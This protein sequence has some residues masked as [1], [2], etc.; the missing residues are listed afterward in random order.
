MEGVMT[1]PASSPKT[2]TGIW[3]SLFS[4][5][6]HFWKKSEAKAKEGRKWKMWRL[7]GAEP[8]PSVAVIHPCSTCSTIGKLYISYSYT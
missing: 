7:D 4:L 8:Q 5:L 2:K 1:A 3:L 6:L